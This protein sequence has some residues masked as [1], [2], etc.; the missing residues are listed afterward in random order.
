[1][2]DAQFLMP[3]DLAVMPMLGVKHDRDM[4]YLGVAHIPRPLPF[5]IW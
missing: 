1:M 3:V 2:A 4:G 5:L